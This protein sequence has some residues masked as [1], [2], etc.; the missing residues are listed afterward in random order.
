MSRPTKEP[1]I[2]TGDQGKLEEHLVE[3]NKMIQQITIAQDERWT[4]LQALQEEKFDQG[5]LLE[6]L[7]MIQQLTIEQGEC[8]T[9]LQALYEEKFRVKGKLLKLL[10]NQRMQQLKITQ[11]EHLK[12]LHTLLKQHIQDQEQLDSS[13]LEQQGTVH[14]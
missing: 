1:E 3:L 10:V 13:N 6:V 12:G 8:W 11:S 4:S 14:R 2:G 7:K 9:S 5:K